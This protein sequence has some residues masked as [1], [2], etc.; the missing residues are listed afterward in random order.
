MDY[1]KTAKA[2]LKNVGGKENVTDLWHCVTRLRFKLSDAN[3]VNIDNIKQIDGVMGAQFSGEQ[4]QVIIGNSVDDVYNATMKQIGKF[5]VPS[6]KS[7]DGLWTRLIGAITSIFT[8]ILPA[9]AGTGLLKGFL[10]LALALNWMKATSG[11]YQVLYILSDCVFYFLPFLLAISSAK[12]FKVNEYLSLALA[13]VLLY[14]TMINAANAVGTS[15]AVSPIKLFNL[16]AVPFVK[17]NNSV[18]PVI[19]AVW[20]F[21]YVFRWVD[22]WMPNP[23]KFM[24]SP[25][26]AFLI[27]VPFE[28]TVLGP[29][30]QYAGELVAGGLV[31][32]FAVAGP[33]AGF[34]FGATYPLMILTGMH[35]ALAPVAMN[36]IAT[37]GYDNMI[38]PIN[39]VTNI[40]Q[41]GASFGVA[42]RTKNSKMKQLAWSSGVSA[43]MGITEPAMYGVNMKLRKPYYFAMFSS[44]IGGAFVGYFGLKCFAMG[45]PG[46]PFLTAFVDKNNSMNIVWMLVAVAISFVLPILLTALLGYDTNLEGKDSHTGVTASGATLNTPSY[47]I[48]A[49]VAGQ[50][51]PLDQAKD[52]TFS[53]G[54]MGGGALI[55]P[56]S[57]QIFAPLSGE[58][59]VLPESK[60][61]IGIVGDNGIEVLIHI[62]IDTVNAK[63][64]GFS[65]NV[66]VGDH[67]STG[68]LL[69][70]V[71]FAALKDAGY[72]VSV[73]VI[74]TNTGNFSAVHQG[75]VG[76]VAAQDPA[77]SI[78]A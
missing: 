4:F 18:I 78:I 10:T 5:D 33:V 69:E 74:V 40:A 32:L 71:D 65:P 47:Q 44:G 76:P 45:V 26:V 72:D 17:Y 11:T 42:L 75:T 73:M 66:K 25:M 50:L 63:G 46:L 34:I 67:V 39:E 77:V 56:S 14:P 43:L 57:N 58:I 36:S 60:H 35:H 64:D 12:H 29:I 68:Q 38:I 51:K 41:S 2:I 61:A 31:K 48:L 3:K 6:E 59:S 1:E 30:G 9:L 55:I 8:P 52:E 20:I 37:V 53:S 49:P 62:G 21:S 70:T 27:V 7:N 22:S 15:S 24:F 23:I 54:L 19:L 28:L 16:I 13:G